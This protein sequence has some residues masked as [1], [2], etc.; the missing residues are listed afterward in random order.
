MKILGGDDLR[1]MQGMAQEIAANRPELLNAEATIGELA[2]VWAKEF[3]A[4]HKYWRYRFWYDLGKLVAWGWAW[5][6]YQITRE[7]GAV[8]HV[9][10]ASLT[11]QTH[12]D[13]P[14]MLHEILNWY[15]GVAPKS[16]HALIVQ[17]SDNVSQDIAAREGYVR[18]VR[19]SA[20]DGDWAQFNIR[21]LSDLPEPALPAGY[22]F[23]TAAAVS[24]EDA[25]IAH[26]QA[27]HPSSFTRA[28]FERVRNT[29]PYRDDLHVFIQASD[30]TL[31]ASAI[32]WLDEVSRTAEFEPVGTHRFHRRKG[33]GKALQ[34][35]GMHRA[36]DAGATRML[37]AFLGAQKHLAA[38]KLYEGVGFE[39][40][41]RDIPFIKYR[42]D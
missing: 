23:T 17:S 30:G 4:L 15:D 37:V 3:D 19:A 11:W 41:S 9:S 21:D 25:V 22:H 6:P 2:W 39:P 40:L 26:K 36:R 38:R 1:A 16:D 12:P 42:Q 10:N 27:W 29:W 34:L 7:N 33:L 14:D 28:A 24:S 35:Y 5:M 13:R 18:D 31:V 8:S 32:I 20:D